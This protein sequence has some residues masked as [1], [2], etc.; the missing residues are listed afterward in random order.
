VRLWKYD[1]VSEPLVNLFSEPR[2]EI[3]HAGL[4]GIGKHNSDAFRYHHIEAV[5]SMRVPKGVAVKIY[6]EDNY[7]GESATVYGPAEVDFAND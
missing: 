7:R 1:P 2:F 3:G 4:F 6:T 5:S